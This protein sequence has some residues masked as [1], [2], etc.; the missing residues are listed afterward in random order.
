MKEHYKTYGAVMLFLFRKANGCK[1][2]LLQQRYNTGYADGMWDCGASG[3][4]DEGESMKAALIREAKEELG[5][6]ID[7]SD[8]HFATLTHKHS[9][10]GSTYYNAFFSVEVYEGTPTIMEP[11]K[12][13]GLQWFDIEHLPESIIEDRREALFNY[14]QNIPYTEKGWK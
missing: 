12:C 3:H 14:L 7:H 5:I 13:S 9:E 1:E 8:V 10:G 11:N 6:T 2:V 4:V